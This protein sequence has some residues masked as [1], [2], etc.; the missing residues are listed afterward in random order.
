MPSLFEPCGLTQMI[1]MRYGTIPLV[2]ETGGLKDTVTAYNQYTGTGDG[3]SFAAFNA[4]DMLY[5]L[6][7]AIHVFTEKKDAWRAMQIAGMKGDYSWTSSAAKY[8]DVY[9]TAMAAK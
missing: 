8:V 3:F 2:R 1:A 7:E 6:E 5:V 4:H 9:K